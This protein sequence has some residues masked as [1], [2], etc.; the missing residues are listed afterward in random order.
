MGLSAF[1]NSAPICTLLPALDFNFRS[2]SLNPDFLTTTVW[3]PSATRTSEGVLPTKLPSTSISAPGGAESICSLAVEVVAVGETAAGITA[4]TDFS[5]AGTLAARIDAPCSDQSLVMASHA[6]CT[7]PPSESVDLL[8][9]ESPLT[10][11]NTATLVLMPQKTFSAF[12]IEK[13]DIVGLLLLV[14]DL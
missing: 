13:N 12:V 1:S 8:T 3:S 14:I 11:L 10:R 7:E 2:Q 4:G 5:G 9:M 6:S